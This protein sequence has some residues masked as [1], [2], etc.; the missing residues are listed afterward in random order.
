MKKDECLSAISKA[1]GGARAEAVVGYWNVR[2]HT[3]PPREVVL[4]NPF[5]FRNIERNGMTTDA[6]CEHIKSIPDSRWARH[7]DDLMVLLLN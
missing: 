7:K 4:S 1:F 3:T 5:V 2:V 6:L